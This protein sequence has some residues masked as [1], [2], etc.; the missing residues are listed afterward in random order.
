VNLV[1][2]L[3]GL[4]VRSATSWVASACGST[5]LHVIV[6]GG[7]YRVGVKRTS[8]FEPE[9]FE[10]VLELFDLESDVVATA[11]REDGICDF[12]CSPEPLR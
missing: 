9:A 7:F 2:D 5:L 1:R 8:V 12:P 4:L 10:I 11:V 3:E 6:D